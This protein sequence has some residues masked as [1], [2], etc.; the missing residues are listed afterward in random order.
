MIEYL[1]IVDFTER[2]IYSTCF[3]DEILPSDEELESIRSTCLSKCPNP[4]SR[5]LTEFDPD[6]NS[7]LIASKTNSGYLVILIV[8]AKQG[9]K[10]IFWPFIDEIDDELTKNDLSTDEKIKLFSQKIG[11]KVKL[12]NGEG[13]KQASSD[14]EIALCPTVQRQSETPPA[15]GKIEPPKMLLMFVIGSVTFMAMLM[16]A[17]VVH[18]L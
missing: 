12:R 18:F 5:F 17:F 4:G 3:F 16:V 11:T 14:L 7:F 8:S 1:F 13:L 15:K 2:M 6:D 9:E 10:P